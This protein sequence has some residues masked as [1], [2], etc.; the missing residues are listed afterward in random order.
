MKQALA[1]S[2]HSASDFLEM[3]FYNMKFVFLSNHKSNKINNNNNDLSALKIVKYFLVGCFRVQRL[4]TEWLNSHLGATFIRHIALQGY[5]KCATQSIPTQQ[6]EEAEKA[7]KPSVTNS[8]SQLGE[9][10]TA[11]G[12]EQWLTHLHLAPAEGPPPPLRW[13]YHRG[14]LGG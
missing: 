12:Q 6:R 14:P 7:P 4:P 11:G 3:W 1:A 5:L 2:L 9:V 13:S 10:V 8:I